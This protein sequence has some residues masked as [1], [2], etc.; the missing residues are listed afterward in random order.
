MPGLLDGNR[1]SSLDE[2]DPPAW[3]ESKSDS[4]LVATCHR[5]RTKPIGEFTVEDLRIM[6]GQSIGLTHL[7][8]LGLELLEKDPLAE[9]DYYPGDLLQSILS[10]DPEFWVAHGA[11]CKRV[12]AILDQLGDAPDEPREAVALFRGRAC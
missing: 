6:I 1:T 12:V 7:V 9:G 3:G 11:W 8:P 2:L 10:V 5:L 4:Y